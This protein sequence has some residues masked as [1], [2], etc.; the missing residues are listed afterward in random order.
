LVLE[1]GIAGVWLYEASGWRRYGAHD[2]HDRSLEASPSPVSASAAPSQERMTLLHE[3]CAFVAHY[4]VNGGC[5]HC[6]GLPHAKDC[7]VGRIARAIAADNDT[8]ERRFPFGMNTEDHRPECDIRTSRDGWDANCTC[9]T[10]SADYWWQETLATRKLLVAAE[11]QV[12]Q[13]STL[14]QQIDKMVSVLKPACDRSWEHETPIQVAHIAANAIHWRGVEVQRLQQERDKLR[15]RWTDAEVD[16]LK[17]QA[18]RAAFE[19]CLQAMPSRT[20][21]E[22][23]IEDAFGEQRVVLR[24]VL[25]ALEGTTP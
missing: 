14:Q 24:K 23:A 3:A 4:T 2:F 6:G 21:V 11:S 13:L 9:G 10:N 7:Y 15:Q 5:G 17:Q 12:Q 20:E 22:E 8:Q 25:R 16:A 1:A 18:T 19:A